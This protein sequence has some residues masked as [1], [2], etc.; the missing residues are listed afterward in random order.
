M[1]TATPPNTPTPR[2]FF[3]ASLRL[4]GLLDIGILLG[5]LC[6][7]VGCFGHWHW[8]LALFDHFRLQGAII[9]LI[10]IL[11]FVLRRRWIL[12][13]ISIISL[14][15]NFW[16]LWRA[17]ST[18]QEGTAAAVGPGLKLISFNVLTR[19]TRYA[20]ALAYLQSQDA[21]VIL[22]LETNEKWVEAMDPLR[23]THPHGR[24]EAQ[25]DNFGL[26]L[27]SRLP[28]TGLEIS[29]LV[30]D[31]MPTVV[32]TVQQGERLLRVIGT[33]PLPP[34]GQATRIVILNQM[35]KIAS[36]VKAQPT[37]PTIVMG[38]FNATPWSPAIDILRTQCDLD[39]R[40]PKPVWR[41]TW[42]ARTIFALPIDHALCTPQV[43]LAQRE[44]GPDLGSD[45]RAQE[46]LLQW[47]AAP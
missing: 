25:E 6:T 11:V 43:F 46:L 10:A 9:C 1:T 23:R 44:I 27:Y 34:T 3:S 28:V 17:T 47:R 40:T 7:W 14:A 24:A 22:L 31:G 19:N 21:D 39:F 42:Q 32:A 30:D 35:A 5:L 2:S 20:D 8:F 4:G 33:H 45:H 38:D 16:P 18:L 29:H 12:L 15:I 13:A 26:A 41:P 36:I 37:L